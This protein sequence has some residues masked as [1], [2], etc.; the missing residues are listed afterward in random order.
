MKI[1]SGKKPGEQFISLLASEL[2]DIMGERQ[3]ALIKRSDG[4]PNTILLLGLQ[5]SNCVETSSSDVYK[6]TKSNLFYRGQE[7]RLHARSWPIGR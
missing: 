1:D 2:V 7:K 6:Y 3:E 5:V 4:R